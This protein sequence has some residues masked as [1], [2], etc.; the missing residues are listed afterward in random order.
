M[1]FV[2]RDSIFHNRECPD[3]GNA[4]FE[5]CLCH[6]RPVTGSLCYYAM[7]SGDIESQFRIPHRCE[8]VR[9]NNDRKVTQANKIQQEPA[10]KLQMSKHQVARRIIQ[11]VSIRL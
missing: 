5:I 1:P 11:A 8:F 4:S 3:L 9:A 6:I 7:K 2:R 10:P